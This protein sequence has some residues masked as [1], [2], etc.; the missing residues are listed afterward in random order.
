MSNL[1]KIKELRPEVRWAGF[2][3]LEEC[4]RRNYQF[5]IREAY[6]TQE[7]QRYLYQQGRTR[8]GNIVTWTLKSWHT[9]R[10]AIDVYPIN[11]TYDQLAYVA[12]HFGITHPLH[13]DKPHFEFTHVGLENP[14]FM[15]SIEAKIKAMKRGIERAS[16]EV[17]EILIRQ[18]ERLQK[19]I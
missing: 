6:R 7:R 2:K 14:V 10:L 19:R 15:P 1:E 11:C 5:E 8:P 12:A 4:K 9:L 16:G 13:F 3:F 18:L 17:K